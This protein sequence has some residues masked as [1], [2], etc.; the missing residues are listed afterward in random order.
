MLQN[1]FSWLRSSV[2][3]AVLGGV[4][5]ALEVIDGNAGNDAS[6]DNH[7]SMPSPSLEAIRRRLQPALTG[8]TATNVGTT[9]ASVPASASNLTQDEPGDETT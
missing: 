2:R 5:D 4:A 9:P 8:P 7:A 6:N 1:L 3:D